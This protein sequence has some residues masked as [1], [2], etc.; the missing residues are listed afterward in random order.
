V[1]NDAWLS[2]TAALP[3]QVTVDLGAQYVVSSYQIEGP[4][5]SVSVNAAPKTWTLAGSNDSVN[6]T[7]ID[8]RTNQA[9]F[10]ANEM[11]E[12]VT[13]SAVLYRYIRLTVS[14]VQ[15]GTQVCLAGYQ[16]FEPVL[17]RVRLFADERQVMLRTL[18][19][20][21]EQWRLPSGFKADFWQFEIEAAIEIFS[22]QAATSPSELSSV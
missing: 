15:S 21:G 19:Q 18:K 12:Y 6:F 11:R 20:S 9:A 16:L 7:T 13:G 14:A 22:L 2:S 3:H 8:T 4:P 17:G 5:P 1:L 10:A